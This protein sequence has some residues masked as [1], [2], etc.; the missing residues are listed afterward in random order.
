[1]A[2]RK[3]YGKSAQKPCG[4]SPPPGSQR[5][6]PRVK[7]VQVKLQAGQKSQKRLS[8][9]RPRTF[10]TNSQALI[11]HCT[12]FAAT[13][14]LTADLVRLTR[15]NIREFNRLEDRRT[16]TPT[17]GRRGAPSKEEI[18]VLVSGLLAAY[19]RCSDGK[20]VTRHYNKD[21]KPSSAGRF[22]QPIFDDLGLKDPDS[23]IKKHH[24]TKAD[25]IEE[26]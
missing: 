23:W 24:S 15:R 6:I 14:K 4:W 1:M 22:I 26:S 19:Y 7:D 11:S 10:L 13:P 5:N 20:T 18:M 16:K 21:A 25:A 8:A 9:D 17:S 3:K 2:V 12:R